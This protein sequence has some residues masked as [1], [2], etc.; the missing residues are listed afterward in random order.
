MVSG[1]GECFRPNSVELRFGVSSTTGS[2]TRRVVLV[3]VGTVS[4]TGSRR[5]KRGIL[6]CFCG[7]IW[8]RL[9]SLDCMVGGEREE[10]WLS[11]LE[12]G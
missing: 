4:A 2:P 12:V 3:E 10:C 11:G 6:Y 9:V 1:S 8:L 5:L 7:C